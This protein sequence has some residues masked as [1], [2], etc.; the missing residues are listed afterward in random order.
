MY[1]VDI[2]YNLNLLFQIFFD[3]YDPITNLIRINTKFSNICIFY[4]KKLQLA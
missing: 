3:I 2:Y 4:N 1:Y